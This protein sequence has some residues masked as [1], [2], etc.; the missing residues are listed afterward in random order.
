MTRTI[1]IA[2]AGVNHN[3]S[4]DRAFQLVD[5]AAAAG[6]DVVKFQTF[7]ADR[8]VTRAAPK[9]AYQ[10]VTTGSED[11]SQYAMLKALELD[12]A[13]HRRLMDHCTA[14]GIQFLST[15]FDLD[16]LDYLVKDLGLG[17]IKLS[18][19]DAANPLMLLAAARSGARLIV[20]TGMCSL[21]EVED[22]LAVLAF[23]LAGG[24]APSRAAFREAWADASARAR[25]REC[26]TVLHCTTEYPAPV[27]DVNLRAMNAMGAALGVSMGYSD[28]TQGITIPVAAVALGAVM[29]E[30]HFTMDCRLPG[31]DHVASLEPDQL[32]AMVA[33]IRQVEL[34]LGD[35]V[36]VAGPAERANMAAAR[37][38]LTAARDVAEGER[39]SPE[40]VTVKRPGTGASPMGYFDLLGRL[41]P[42]AYQADET[43]E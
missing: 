12:D 1:V 31:P 36:K 18:S 27:A 32:A 2:E 7:S 9:A 14:R 10:T 25:L 30:K 15:P 39:F 21:A 23:G 8:L 13:A 20:S 28:H 6:A 5:A 43:I 35:G 11:S 26:V 19:G 3:G 16:S 24:T 41:A 37:K 22:M 33:G 34:A 42:R 38:S 40:N 4:L 29:I 17:T